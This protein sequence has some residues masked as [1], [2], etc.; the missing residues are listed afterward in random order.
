MNGD[1][2]RPDHEPHEAQEGHGSFVPLA[3]SVVREAA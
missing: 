1:P 3:E 2:A